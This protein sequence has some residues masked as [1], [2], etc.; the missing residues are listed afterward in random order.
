MIVR[1]SG[2]PLVQDCL[3]RPIGV[4]FGED[5]EDHVNHVDRGELEDVSGP[6]NLWEDLGTVLSIMLEGVLD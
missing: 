4:P 2:Y 6:S 3:S 5:P 1:L